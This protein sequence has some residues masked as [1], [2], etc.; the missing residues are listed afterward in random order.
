MQKSW[1][2]HRHRIYCIY[3][4]VTLV[5][6]IYIYKKKEKDL[7]IATEAINIP[8]ETAASQKR[9]MRYKIQ[10]LKLD[11]A[12]HKHAIDR[13]KKQ[14]SGCNFSVDNYSFVAISLVKLFQI[15]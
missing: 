8:R 11:K 3:Q 10:Q 5:I 15:F 6:S 1:N 4:H 2:P 9:Y 13:E 7:S 14:L 12:N